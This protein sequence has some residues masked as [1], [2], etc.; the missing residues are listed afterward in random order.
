M[1]SLKKIYHKKKEK[2]KQQLKLL[3]EGK[4]P[5]SKLNKLAKK[6]LYKRLKAGH[7]LPGK[8]SSTN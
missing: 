4:I 7:P 2:A 5:F 8:S 6:I 3:Q 1:R